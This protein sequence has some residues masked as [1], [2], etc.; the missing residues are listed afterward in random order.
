M[1]RARSSLA[2][3]MA[4]A[5]VAAFATAPAIAAT[6]TIINGNAAGV[7]FNDP[8]AVAPVGGNPRTTLGG[9]RL[10]VFEEAAAIWGGLIPSDVTIRVRASFIT[11]ACDATGAV[12]GSA[13]P[14][15][16]SRDFTG[17]P[18]T[19]TW[20]HGALANKL[21]GR[22]L[23]PGED[24]I[25][26]RFNSAIDVGTCPGN[27]RWYYGLDHQHGNNYDLLAVVLHEIG[28]GLGF[29]TLINV[30]TGALA[31]GGD[32]HPDAFSRFLLDTQT[33]KHWHEMTNAERVASAKNGVHLVWD[34]PAV[35]TRAPSVL[36]AGAAR[37]TVNAPASIA[38]DLDL[39]LAPFG[40]A[41]GNPGITA[42]IVLASPADG[43]ATLTNAAQIAG[44]IALIDRGTCPFV[45]KA[46]AAQAAGAV[47]VVVANNVP[48]SPA[49][50]AGVA[51]DVT[52][53]VVGISQ[54]DGDDIKDELVNGVNATIFFDPTRLAGAD[55]QGRVRL[56]A[57]TPVDP[58]SS[59]SHWDVSATPNLL[60]EPFINAD[61]TSSVDLT[62]QSFEDLGWFLPGGDGSGGGT[63]PL[64]AL[65]R[66]SGGPNPFRKRATSTFSVVFALERAA[67]L[68]GEITDT[69][70]RR[71]RHLF[72]TPLDAGTYI[73]PGGWDGT[74]DDGRP[75]DSG[76]YFVHVHSGNEGAAQKI[77]LIR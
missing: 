32:P 47:A 72:S 71:V 51:P 55:A 58:G 12:L 68:D 27:Q 60:M 25:L 59:V 75:V 28:H 17:A 54:S 39:S 36:Q 56:Y 69:R 53:P 9:Q 19:D 11:L 13:G 70:G 5:L 21:V 76:L 43:C 23:A 31:P 16:V 4:V 24:D 30:E 22:D 10:R 48:G 37:I 63:T 29:S 15:T 42:G 3:A 14:L 18:A 34:G 61:L 44:K 38:G 46:R 7:G 65:L 74:D 73:V 35:T 20:Y 2:F 1:S 40:P 77:A 45:D 62:L 41:P 50:M 64:P 8:S 49:G 66:L 67:T 52:I 33:N 6:I 57:P 26:A